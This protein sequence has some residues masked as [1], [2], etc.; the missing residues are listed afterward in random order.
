MP[1]YHG[2]KATIIPGNKEGI[3]GSVIGGYNIG[4][5]IYSDE[6]KRDASVQALMHITSREIQKEMMLKYKKFSGIVNLFDDLDSC[7]KDDFCDV[8]RKIQPIARPTSLTDDYNSYSEKFRY[9]IYEYIYGNDD[10]DPLDMLSK[11]NDI[12]YFNYISIKT[13]YSSLGKIFGS[14]Y[15]TI[16]IL[17]ILSSCFLYNKNFQ[18]YY[19]FLSKDYWI[20]TL[21]GYIFVIVTSYLDMEKVTPVH[22]RLKQLFH[23]LSYTLIFIPVFHKLVSNYPEEIPYQNWFHNHRI[24]FMIVFIIVDIGVWGLTLFSSS[25]SEDIKVTNGKNFQK[26]DRY[27]L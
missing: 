4:L 23:L 24:L 27:L 22:C 19:S 15:L 21:I 5:S 25:T 7:D 12:T 14:I 6:E 26:Y 10:I 13:K 11:I 8:H 1:I 17:I 9:Y 16:S 18:F 20:L 3:S 2:F